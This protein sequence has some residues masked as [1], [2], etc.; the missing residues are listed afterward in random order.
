MTD[1]DSRTGSLAGPGAGHVV[2]RWPGNA[3]LAVVSLASR[4]QTRRGP[5]VVRRGVLG[6]HLPMKEKG[7]SRYKG[8]LGKEDL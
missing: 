3:A 8:F 6:F 2:G 1:W 7:G 4:M 5:G